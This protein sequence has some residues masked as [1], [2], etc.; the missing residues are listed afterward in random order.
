MSGSDFDYE[1]SG[2]QPWRD[3]EWVQVLNA[4]VDERGKDA[5]AEALGCSRA[6]VHQ[7][8]EAKYGSPVEKWRRKVM[9]ELARDRV[10]CPVLGAIDVDECREHRNAEFAATNPERIRLYR[11][12]PTCPNNPDNDIDHDD[13]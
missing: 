7:L 12:C 2:D 4:E 3:E 5:V 6:M 10:Q 9:A 13:S 1:P 11:T 8:K